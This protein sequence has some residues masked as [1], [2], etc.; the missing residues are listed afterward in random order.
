[1]VGEI[2]AEVIVQFLGHLF[3]EI[4]FNKIISPIL[5][6]IGTSFRWIYFLG[7]ISFKEIYKKD[8]NTRFG[9]FITLS[10]I[11]TMIILFK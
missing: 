8:Y 1:M 11:I 2:I 5:K 3:I 7:K 4:I 10:I 9:F 6:A